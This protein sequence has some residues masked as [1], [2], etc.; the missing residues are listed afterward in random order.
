MCTTAN[1]YGKPHYEYHW[2]ECISSSIR[3]T[4]LCRRSSFNA[5]LRNSIVLLEAYS[6]NRISSVPG[7][8]TA[9]P[10]RSNQILVSPYLVYARKAGFDDIAASYGNQ[11]QKTLML[12]SGQSLHAYVNYA[13]GDESMETL[14]GY[15]SWRIRKLRNLKAEYDP[16]SSSQYYTPTSGEIWGLNGPCGW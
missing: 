7:D 10:D 5:P 15:E 16:P 1:E 11:I 8:S 12:G 6:T 4:L 3:N 9:Y 14:Y 13:H 2:D